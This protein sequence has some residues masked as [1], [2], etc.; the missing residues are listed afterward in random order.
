MN[1]ENESWGSGLRDALFS[2]HRVSETPTYQIAKGIAYTLTGG[3]ALAVSAYVGHL[4]EVLK[5]CESAGLVV[6]GGLLFLG[7]IHGLV[8]FKSGE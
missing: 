7:V 3:W 4:Y 8:G 5:C 6:G 2:P 1:E